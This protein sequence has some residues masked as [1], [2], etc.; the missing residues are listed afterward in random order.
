MSTTPTTITTDDEEGAFLRLREFFGAAFFL[1]VRRSP[2]LLRL[3]RNEKSW[4]LFRVV[5]GLFGAALVVLPLSL[6]TG[7]ITAIFGMLFFVASI[8]LP[9]A[10]VESGTDRKAREL[11]AKTVVGGGIYQ[12][13]NA[14]AA[15]VQ[16]FISPVHIWALDDH[17]E[18]LLVINTS[19]VSS[20]RIEADEDNWLLRLRWADHKAEFAFEGFFA[21]R[22]ARLAEDSIRG[23]VRSDSPASPKALAA[24]A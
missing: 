12:P 22:F 15:E 6:W 9:P 21:E 24:G 1:I 19:E 4:A 13:G 23:V 17:L 10:Q 16:L 18:P 20:L 2:R 7:W 11:G 14:P 5:L 3:H 8:L